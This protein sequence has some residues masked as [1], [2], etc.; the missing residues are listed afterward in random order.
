MTSIE[1]RGNKKDM[2]KELFIDGVPE[3]LI[4]RLLARREMYGYELVNQ[5]RIS[6]EDVFKFGEGCIYPILHRLVTNRNL[7]ERKEMVSGRTRRYYRLTAN[8]KKHLAR[9]EQS[10]DSVAKGV[11]AFGK[12]VSDANA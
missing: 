5:I 12:E 10:W 8:G 1:V 3:L 6:S 9:L 2:A 4:L 7:S 11:N